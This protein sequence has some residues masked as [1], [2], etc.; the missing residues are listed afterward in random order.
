MTTE[1]LPDARHNLPRDVNEIAPFTCSNRTFVHW[2]RA[3]GSTSVGP[4]RLGRTRSRSTM[5]TWQ[6]W[7]HWC[8]SLFGIYR[9]DGGPFELARE[10][11][12]SVWSDVTPLV[13]FLH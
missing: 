12:T 13:G 2:V 5:V 10:A 6:P 8:E 9:P 3:G 7:C 1:H 11:A 4:L